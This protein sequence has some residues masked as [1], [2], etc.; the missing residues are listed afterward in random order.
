[1]DFAM[2]NFMPLKSNASESSV[3]YIDTDASLSDLHDCALQRCKAARDL[4]E[5]I[6]SLS[7]NSSDDQDLSAF[8]T[9]AWLLLQDG[10]DALNAIGWK[11]VL[12]A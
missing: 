2:P 3:F 1:M 6:A 9:A 5:S 8:T 11:A 4:M 12:R 10:C 7:F